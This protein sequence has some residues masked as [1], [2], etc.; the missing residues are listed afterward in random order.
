MSL[1]AKTLRHALVDG[2]KLLGT[3]AGERVYGNRT[4]P[5]WGFENTLPAIVVYTKRDQPIEVFSIGPPLVERHALE[6]VV[7]IVDLQATLDAPVDDRLDDVAE[8]VEAAIRRNPTFGLG[9]ELRGEEGRRWE[10]EKTLQQS[11]E[12]VIFALEGHEGERPLAAQELT[13]R[14]TFLQEAGEGA[15]EDVEPF[16]GFEASWRLPPDDG[17]ED[18]RDRVDLQ[19]S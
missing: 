6:I 16:N 15:S 2:L 9:Y 18:A 19:G 5:L 4:R 3:A 11:A 8:V 12:L 7:Q 10:I 17:L 13:F 14:T 1:V